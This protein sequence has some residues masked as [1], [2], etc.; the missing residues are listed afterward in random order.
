MTSESATSIT[1]HVLI[2]T[3]MLWHAGS[4]FLKHPDFRKLLRYAKPTDPG[5]GRLKIYVSHIGWEERR[6]QLVDDVKS[7]LRNV[8]TAF[9][10]LIRELENN[11]VCN[12]LTPPALTTWKEGEIEA[13]SKEAMKTFAAENN[14]EVVAL[15]FDQTER[16]WRRYFEVHPPFNPDQERVDRR[17]DI[18]DSWIL[19]AAIDLNARHPGLLALCGDGRLSDAMKSMDIR[20][21][22]KMQGGIVKSGVRMLI[23]RRSCFGELG[24][25]CARQA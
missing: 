22:G 14:I 13:Y 5:E 12:G 9:G 3:G 21:L 1:L 18:P 11:I 7:K 10:G 17:K 25:D 19:E 4:S 6:T 20:V 23:R 8:T 2:D 16:A 15:T 24:A